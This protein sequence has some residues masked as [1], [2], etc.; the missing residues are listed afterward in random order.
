MIGTISSIYRP[1]V[2]QSESV[3]EQRRSEFIINNTLRS[4][5]LP[6]LVTA[7]SSQAFTVI[8]G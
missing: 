2:E 5:T 6:F 3:E 7:K 1:P 4:Q 8:A